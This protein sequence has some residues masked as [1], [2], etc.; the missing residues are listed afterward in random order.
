MSIVIIHGPMASGKT[1]RA[2]QLL[3]HYKCKRIVDCWDGR[4][5]LMDGDLALTNMEPPFNVYGAR[6]VNIYDAKVA[7]TSKK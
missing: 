7:I 4:Q 5:A 1:R 3:R 2:T 6:A